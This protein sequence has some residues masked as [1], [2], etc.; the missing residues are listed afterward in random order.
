MIKRTL[1]VLVVLLALA[2]A[3]AA[4]GDGAYRGRTDQNRLV[5]FK[6]RAGKVVGFQ[7]GVMTYCTTQGNNRFETD[8]IAKLPP[9]PIRGNRFHLKKDVQRDGT[10]TIEVSGTIVGAK[11]KGKVT[12]S[13]PDSNYDASAGMTYF[14]ACAANDRVYSAARD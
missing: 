3:A 1:P 8:A 5:T 10:I 9:I 12:L 2:P 11:V 13:R 14:G 4:A 7:S 6:I